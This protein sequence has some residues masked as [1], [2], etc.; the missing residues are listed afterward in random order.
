M[1]KRASRIKDLV[2]NFFPIQLLFL[3]LRKNLFG[4]VVWAILFGFVGGLSSRFGVPQ[5]FLSPEYMGRVDNISFLI[6]GIGLGG[7]ITAYN[8]YS[9]V[10]LGPQ[11]P[12]LGTCK[13][14]LVVF[15]LNNFI[16]PTIFLVFYF[17][18]TYHFQRFNELKE[19]F[20]VI[21][22]FV[23]LIIGIFLFV[24]V[25]FLYFFKTNKNIFKLSGKSQSDFETEFMANPVSSVLHRDESWFQ[26]FRKLRFQKHYYITEGFSI[27]IARY[28]NH[29]DK[30]LIE[31]VFY[32]NH[33]NTSIFEI[34]VIASFIV[35]GIFGDAVYLVIPAGASIFLIFSIVL[36]FISAVYSWFRSWAYLILASVFLFV[37]Y[38]S[39]NPNFEQYTYPAFGLDYE[40]VSHQNFDSLVFEHL[41][42]NRI[43]AEKK[44]YTKILSK[45]KDK[46]DAKKPKLVIVNVSGGGS[47]SALW[48]FLVLRQLDSLTQ[49][50]FSNSMH[51]IT[52]ASGGMIG[53]SYYRELLLQQAQSERFDLYK[54]HY[55]DNISKELLNSVATAITTRDI[56]FKYKKFEYNGKRYLKDRGHAFELQL[57]RNTD[58]VMEKTLADYE[59]HEREAQIPVMVFSPTLI[60]DGRRLLISSVETGFY[61]SAYKNKVA[62]YY[63]SVED[64]EYRILMR[65]FGYKQTRF[66]SILRMSATFPY[67][68]PMVKLPGNLHYHVMDAGI[69][70]N[71]GTK[72]TLKFLNAFEDWIERNTSGVLIVRIRDVM[73]HN[74]NVGEQNYSISEKLF[75]PLGN[76]LKNFIYVQDFEQ[77]DQLSLATRNH[78][79]PIHV[80]SFDLRSKMDDEI[81]LSFR[82]TSREKKMVR[83]MLRAERNQKSFYNVQRILGKL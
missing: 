76:M 11:I 21:L 30:K 78:N 70:D 9:Y 40:K 8:L 63:G 58:F 71:M 57:H 51:M 4:L 54:Q 5:L 26:S 47:R 10:L 16:I 52:G 64:M 12:F 69:R 48:S 53:A 56:F 68:M 18:K 46:Q 77:D 6:L 73:R 43:E 65:D 27:R 41:D 50:D 31:K 37:N 83:E 17:T 49:G 34:F 32:Q 33:V 45:W 80:V 2:L 55:I 59:S 38:L 28:W 35:F 60:N 61:Q 1:Q 15:S 20:D 25:A 42:K 22:E 62:D 3:Q 74:S 75:L 81:A 72:T 67:I 39:R 7:F 36:M 79:V 14:P 23:Y 19:V 82:L 13:R 66:S 24:F 44:E 29:Y